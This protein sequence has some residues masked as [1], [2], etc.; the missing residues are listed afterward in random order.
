MKKTMLVSLSVLLM[1]CSGGVGPADFSSMSDH[2]KTVLDTSNRDYYPNETLIVE[3]KVQFS[4]KNYGNAYRAFKE[5]IDLAPQDP[6]AWLGY[7]AAA[8]MLKRFDK[9]EFA[10]QK[11][12]PVIGNRIEFLNNY[13]YSQLLRGNLSAARSY[14]L[15]AYE[16]DP[17]NEFAA[18]NLETLRNSVAYQRR[19]PGDLRGI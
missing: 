14:F 7:A 10:Y 13:G 1:S 12:R 6:Q 18:N 4:S 8:D 9:A 11:L 15:K 3:G 5:A 16:L 19:S 2:A 17:S